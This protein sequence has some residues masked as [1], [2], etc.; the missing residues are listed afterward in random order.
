MKTK[1]YSVYDSKS[2]A[3]QPPSVFR[4]SDEAIRQFGVQITEPGSPFFKYAEDFSLFE[5][6]SFD[7]ES[8]MIESYPPIQ[9]VTAIQLSR[10]HNEYYAA[11]NLDRNVA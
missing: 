5:C 9:V 11:R 1:I 6:G 10:Q 2:K 8:G 7:D 3:F 4:T